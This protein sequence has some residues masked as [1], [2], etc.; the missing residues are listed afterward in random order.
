MAIRRSK[1]SRAC[2]SQY[3]QRS[4]LKVID[5]GGKLSVNLQLIKHFDSEQTSQGNPPATLFAI[6][7]SLVAFNALALIQ[8]SLQAAQGEKA[9]PENISGYFLALELKGRRS[10]QK[11]LRT[12]S[13]QIVMPI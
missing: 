1:F 3:L 4:S 2:P 13:G 11:L 8:M 9:K 6:A 12:I 7:V 10:Q 5:A